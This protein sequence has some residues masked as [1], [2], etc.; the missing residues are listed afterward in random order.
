MTPKLCIMRYVGA[1]F[2]VLKSWCEGSITISPSIMLLI[3]KTIKARGNS[4]QVKG[5]F[6]VLT[7]SGTYSTKIIYFLLWIFDTRKEFIIQEYIPEFKS[8]NH[9][10]LLEFPL[11]KEDENVTN[12]RKRNPINERTGIKNMMMQLV[13]EIH[14]LWSGII[15]NSP[16]KIYGEG[17]INYEVVRDYMESKINVAYVEKNSTE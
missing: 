16:T 14:H 9:E 13:D 17:A 3:V 1:F 4:R 5:R 2:G 6:V 7:T 8:M 10:D 15:H 12:R 11:H